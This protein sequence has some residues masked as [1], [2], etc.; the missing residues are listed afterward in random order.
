LWSSLEEVVRGLLDRMRSWPLGD[1]LFLDPRYER[2]PLNPSFFHRFEVEEDEDRTM[3]F[4]DGGN[5]A[6]IDTPSVVIQLC[7]L[8]FCKYKGE[9]RVA[10][11]SLPQRLDF[12]VV[13]QAVNEGR[14]I[15]YKSTLHARDKSLRWLMPDEADLYFSSLDRS[16]MEGN[17]RARLSRASSAARVFAEWRLASAV[18]DR[19]LAP[20]DILVR[21]GSLHTRIRG[22]YNY[23]DEAY[24]S[25]NRRNV[26]FTGL[27]KTSTLF[28]DSGM[29][30][31]AAISK[32]AKRSGFDESRWFYHPIVEI[33]KFDHR[34]DM[35][36]VKL[37]PRS[38]YV[39]R[40]E[41]LKDQALKL[42]EERRKIFSCLAANSSDIAFPGYPYGLIE[43]DRFARVSEE[44]REPLEIQVKS[45]ISSQGFWSDL[46]PL[47]RT[48]D[49]HKRLN[50]I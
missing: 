19:E 1:P 13:S 45:A 27:S 36:A 34:A 11:S 28:T 47:I 25:A 49:A 12:F 22:E 18:I 16:L 44:E 46:E 23:A 39:F 17:Q 32:L 3:C 7:R 2:K 15:M 30:L 20:G 21:D 24:E 9:V 26:I 6:I 29:A 37:H 40:F 14:K 41:I 43:A 35:Y 42:G 10:P 5:I 50:E 4:V 33:N 48:T 38:E 31:L 8:Y